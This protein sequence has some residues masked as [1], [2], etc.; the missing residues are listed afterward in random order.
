MRLVQ[1]EGG[2]VV[3][4]PHNEGRGIGLA[5]KVNAY[6]LQDDAQLDTYKANVQLGVE[7]DA[8]TYE[9]VPELLA[10]YGV[11]KIMLLTNSRTKLQRMRSML[12]E[13][14]VVGHRPVVVRHSLRAAAYMRAKREKSL[15]DEGPVFAT[16]AEAIRALRAGRP[17][18]VVDDDDRENEGDLIIAAQH[19][20]EL[21]TRNS[22]DMARLDEVSRFAR[23]HDLLLVRIADM[24][25]PAT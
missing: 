12:G 1:R 9:C 19:C 22:L 25:T 14:A 13:D 5:A 24:L 11:Q 20:T 8:R 2:L 10:H 21:T 17:V 4:L 18:V 3:H 6:K 16:E 23:E 15:V 7:E